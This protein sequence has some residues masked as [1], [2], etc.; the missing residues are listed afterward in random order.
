MPHTT[1]TG[2]V[3]V[4]GSALTA[5]VAVVLAALVIPGTATAHDIGAISLG[6]GG[7]DGV[8]ATVERALG[9]G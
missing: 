5:A 7:A 6:G 2:R 3:R 8:P 4:I 9:G 1:N